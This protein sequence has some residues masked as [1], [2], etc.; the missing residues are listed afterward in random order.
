[1]RFAHVRG[2]VLTVAALVVVAGLLAGC[3]TNR[4]EP[5]AEATQPS[6]EAVDATPPPALAGTS[7]IVESLGE[8]A[9]KVESLPDVQSSL[10]FLIDRYGGNGGCNYY[11]G[12]F[13]AEEAD[14]TLETP[15]R[16]GATCAE[17]PASL[18]QEN[19]FMSA[20]ATTARYAIADDKLELFAANGQLM[21]TLAPLEAAPLQGTPWSLQFVN[22]ETQWEATMADT[23]ITLRIEDGEISGSSGCNNYQ[24]A[25]VIESG[26]IIVTD[27]SATEMA[28]P[29]PEGV[30]EQETLYLSLLEQAALVRQFPQS[31]ELL[32]AEG[33]PL[34]LFGAI[35]VAAE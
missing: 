20:L 9:D 2:V 30:M 3:R 1:M 18:T 26:E 27:L 25:I 6:V 15:A 21:L 32:D 13:G 12:V 16:T 14:L 23:Q 5:D 33:M 31:L 28:C 17:A 4:F 35:D 8:G 19:V 10:G 29:E 11:V 22:V 7:W 34:L 24:G